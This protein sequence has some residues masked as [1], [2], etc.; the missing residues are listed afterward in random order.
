MA[1][2]TLTVILGAGPGTGQAIGMAF[3]KVNSAVALLAR[4][5]DS[6]EQVKQAI[7]QQGG[8]A[9]GFSCDATS[10]E[11]IQQA[12]K[13]IKQ[14]WPNHELKTAIFNVNNP[15]IM[16]PF[17]DLTM[18]DLKPGLD[19]NVYGAFHFSQT[20]I[21]L[22]LESKGGGGTL[23]FS[24]ATASLKG[25]SNF[26]AFS[27]SKFALRGLSQSLAREFGPKGVHVCHV[28][29]DGLIDTPLIIDKMG[30]SQH[31]K[32]LTPK[33]I[34]DAYVYLASQTKDSW[35]HELDLRPNEEKW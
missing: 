12:F 21:P 8:T 6:L 13:Q 7:E 30:S 24:G 9:Q 28:V 3:S 27:P 22:L 17:L 11:S 16:K 15:F 18:N 4:R 2:P 14:T 20:V 1:R 26:V 35:T 33:G 19:I 29:L 5:Q 10:L 25:S 34:A 31:G 23:I 32:R